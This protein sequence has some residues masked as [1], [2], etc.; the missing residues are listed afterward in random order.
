ME[1]LCPRRATGADFALNLD[2]SQRRAVVGLELWSSQRR[3]CRSRREIRTSGLMS[4]IW[5]RRHGQL[6]RHR[7]TERVGKQFTLI[8]TPPRQIS[9][10]QLGE[11]CSCSSSCSWSICGTSAPKRE[12]D[13]SAIILFHHPDRDV[14]HR[15]RAGARLLNF[16]V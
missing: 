13:P 10:L 15:G 4:G 9:T 6:F 14:L 2:L 3:E 12:P 11:S 1:A 16:G 5:K 8:L 7:H